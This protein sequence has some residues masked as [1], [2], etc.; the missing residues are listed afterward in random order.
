MNSIPALV[1][2]M[3]WRRP[4]DKP[5]SEPMMVRLPTHICVT[6]PQWVN[7][8]RLRD[9]NIHQWSR[10]LLVQIMACCLLGSK[11]LSEPLLTY[12]QLNHKEKNQCNINWSSNIF[13]QENVFETVVW[14]IAA[15][16]SQPQCVKSSET[17]IESLCYYFEYFIS[18]IISCLLAV[19]FLG[20]CWSNA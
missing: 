8:L 2:I 5:L 4:G 9:A 1:Q 13:F 6:R 19:F 16:L 10:P 18:V 14:K 3:A 12:S 17:T 15:I 20:L 11:P 7:S